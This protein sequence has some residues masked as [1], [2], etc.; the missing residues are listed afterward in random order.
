MGQADTLLYQGRLL[1]QGRILRQCLSYCGDIMT[2]SQ[3]PIFAEKGGAT[4]LPVLMC[5]AWDVTRLRMHLGI[6]DIVMRLGS[7]GAPGMVLLWRMPERPEWR[8][9]K[10][11]LPD[12]S[13]TQLLSIHSAEHKTFHDKKEKIAL[14]C[15]DH[16][17]LKRAGTQ[18]ISPI[19]L[20]WLHVQNDNPKIELLEKLV[21]DCP[22]ITLG[23]KATALRLLS[24]ATDEAKEQPARCGRV[25]AN[26][27]ARGP[28]DERAILLSANYL[29]QSGSGASLENKSPGRAAKSLLGYLYGDDVATQ[30]DTTWALRKLALPSPRVHLR[31]P[32]LLCLFLG[33]G[34]IIT[35]SELDFEEIKGNLIEVNATA[36]GEFRTIQVK[37]DLSE[38]QARQIVIELDCKYVDFHRHAVA[39]AAAGKPDPSRFDIL[40]AP[41]GDRLGQDILTPAKWIQ[42]LSSD[43]IEKDVFFLSRKYPSS[44]VPYERATGYHAR[45]NYDDPVRKYENPRRA[46]LHRSYTGYR[47]RETDYFPRP[48]RDRYSGSVSSG[49]IES[50]SDHESASGQSDQGPAPDHSPGNT[51]SETRS[52]PNESARERSRS[53]S[54]PASQS[55]GSDDQQF[56]GHHEAPP[57][58]SGLITFP[59][60]TWRVKHGTGG[61][62]PGLVSIQER[63]QTV[64][65]ILAKIHESITSDTSSYRTLYA[66]AYRCAA[67]DLFQR[68]PDVVV[69]TK[70][71][72]S[73]EDNDRAKPADELTTTPSRGHDRRKRQR[74]SGTQTKAERKQ[75]RGGVPPGGLLIDQRRPKAG[76]EKKSKQAEGATYAEADQTGPSGSDKM[77]APIESGEGPSKSEMMPHANTKPPSPPPAE[78]ANRGLVLKTQL[79]EVSQT[80]FRAFLP[81]QGASSYPDYYHP[82][83]ERF[84]GSLDEIFRQI[85]WSTTLYRNNLQCVVRDFDRV[86]S[87]PANL[88]SDASNK[89]KENFADCEACRKNQV[90]NS[91]S[92]AVKHIHEVHFDCT[93]AEYE[94]RLHDDPCSVWIKEAAATLDQNAAMIQEA[95]DLMEFLSS[96]SGMLNQIQ[97][98][99]ASTAK[100]VQNQTSRPQLPR[101]LVHA[102]DAL[103]SYYIF[104]AKQFSLINRSLRPTEKPR[105]ST[106]LLGVRLQRVK[107]RCRKV[108]LDVTDLLTNAKKDILLQGTRDQDEDA[109]GLRAVSAEFLMAALVTTVQNRNINLPDAGGQRSSDVIDMYKKYNSQIHFE[110]NR[111]PQRRVFIA[112]HELEEELRALG[113]VLESQTRLLTWYTGKIEPRY[114]DSSYEAYRE[115]YRYRFEKDYIERQR[116]ILS[117]RQSDV[118]RLQD[119]AAA[120]KQH[121]AQM[122]AVLE[123]DHGKAI[124]V[125]TIVTLFFLP[126]SFVTSFMGMNTN[127]IRNMDSNQPLFWAVAAPLTILV[128]ATAFIYGYK[129]DEV[130]DVLRRCVK[131]R[132]SVLIQK[133]LF[134]KEMRRKEKQVA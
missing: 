47:E 5:I 55:E 67:D 96:V 128:L 30:K 22:F 93:T 37:R 71:D 89:Q 24:R 58:S 131:R 18:E 126:L 125:F 1:R 79:L 6:T 97:W 7:T 60:F 110:A 41:A 114:S 94:D 36:P 35:A 124:R 12:G 75:S 108:S 20:R 98:L 132:G 73:P 120:L 80:I 59:F 116:R 29:A 106:D 40:W 11:R 104:T 129:S 121:V 66:K 52:A 113:R 76:K 61:R 84:W 130:E 34:L 70:A 72:G 46:S 134:T 63:D 15:L 92:D 19:K 17:V 53:G 115:P 54:P 10:H 101:S 105:A 9:P 118:T 133:T 62:Q 32:K 57:K 51:R 95:Q 123:E 49:T 4:E 112:I 81:S 39:I 103:L 111:R 14:V 77:T 8:E 107:R 2:Q 38:K 117:R 86:L 26:E 56:H 88:P 99:V 69:K 102:F 100:G 91:P 64:V 27:N 45:H 48:S 82:L 65:R 78:E 13:V 85:T 16:Q 33:A 122:L 127:D 25:E 83:C 44:N 28:E 90:Y 31:V 68:H 109:L 21:A 42:L 74:A 119:K 87:V 23:L 43:T 50:K 3:D